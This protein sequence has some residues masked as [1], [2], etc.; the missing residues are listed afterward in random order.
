VRS[1]PAAIFFSASAVLIGCTS[2][3]SSGSA[4][5]DVFFAALREH[6]GKA[7]RGE[8]VRNEPAAPNDPFVGQ[9]L[10]MHVRTCTE[11]QIRIP[12]HVGDDHSR[13]WVL[14]KTS[15]GVRLEHDHRHRDG[16]SD[17]LTM[18]GGDTA[19]AGTA[20][21]LEFPAS[22]RSRELFVK[23]QL[24]AST[25]N[26]WAMEL[27]PEKRF[28]YELTRPGRVFRAEFDLTRAVA[29]PPAPWGH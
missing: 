9:E 1:I 7:Y 17:E 15:T 28:A 16:A 14:T 24:P 4:P 23:K 26:V 8:I 6:C 5:R 18:Y 12:F 29:T 3:P 20:H 13:T 2:K 10:I 21:R 11:D 22:A 19:T 27:G 25:A